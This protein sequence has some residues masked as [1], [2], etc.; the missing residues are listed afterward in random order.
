MER[1]ALNPKTLKMLE[2]VATLRA[3]LAQW[4]EWGSGDE[5]ADAAREAALDDAEEV[6]GSRERAEEAMEAAHSSR[7]LGR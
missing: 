7:V 1:S 4:G 3:V 6:L 5:Q 2:T